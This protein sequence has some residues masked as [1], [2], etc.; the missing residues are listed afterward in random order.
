M[1]HLF[2]AILTAALRFDLSQLK[3]KIYR[4]N[5]GLKIKFAQKNPIWAKLWPLDSQGIKILDTLL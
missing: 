5:F 1:M 2:V 4:K 3:T